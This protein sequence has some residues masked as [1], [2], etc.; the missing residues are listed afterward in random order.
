MLFFQIQASG[1]QAF[2]FR[3]DVSNEDDEKSMMRAVSAVC[4]CY[5]TELIN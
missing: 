5:G 3:A 2:P 1:G 4:L